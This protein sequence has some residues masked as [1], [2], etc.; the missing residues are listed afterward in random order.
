[1]Q[2]RRE[3]LDDVL[4]DMAKS[5]SRH[6][7][8][9]EDENKFGL[10]HPYH[11]VKLAVYAAESWGW[12][13]TQLFEQ[14]AHFIDDMIRYVNKRDE[15]MRDGDDSPPPERYQAQTIPFPDVQFK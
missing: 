1:M 10:Y 5:S 9:P 4:Y 11:D 8:P 6:R 14:D 13:P 12:T 7:P 15:F 2:R 3:W